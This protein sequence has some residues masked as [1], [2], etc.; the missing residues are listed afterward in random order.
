MKSLLF[1]NLL[2]MS[3]M[4][5][6][7]LFYSCSDDEEEEFESPSI[8]VT[9]SATSAEEGDEITFDVSISAPEGF[10]R[11]NVY[12]GVDGGD[13]T[14]QDEYT[15][16]DIDGAAAGD[17]E[18]T[19]SISTTL[20]DVEVG[21]VLTFQFEVVDA[22][23]QTATTE[24]D[25]TITSPEARVYSAVLLAAPLGDKSGESFFST[26]DG[27]TYSPEEV[28]STSAAISPNIDFGYYYGSSDHASIASPAGFLTTVFSAQVSAWNTKN[29]TVIKSTDLG[30]SEFTEVTT[31]ADIDEVFD[32]G[33]DE[34]G[35][36]SNLEEGSVVA[37]ETVSG[38]RGLILVSAI[39]DGNGDGQ[40]D[41]STD[42]IQL[43]II[44]Q[45]TAE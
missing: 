14:F 44:V 3:A 33:T 10:D 32:A 6:M 37:F 38:V 13:L 45:E 20:D 30:E 27:E 11:Y 9:A 12:V 41:G 2:L 40:Y 31:Y 24:I 16:D 23:N 34:E 36:I 42:E 43:E 29:A 28:E 39:V 19:H 17:L 22:E 4:S 5:S 35:I 15:V 26:S 18:V 1:R 7:A 21:S 8:S 25:I